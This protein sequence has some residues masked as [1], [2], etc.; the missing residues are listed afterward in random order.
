MST[1]RTDGSRPDQAG[2]VLFGKT[3]R[4]VLGWLYGHADQ[5]FYLREI[6]RQAGSAQGAVQRELEALTRAGLL[7]RTVRG[8]HVYFQAN[9]NSLIYVELQQILLK[10]AGLTD[11]LREAL[12]PLV[13]SIRVAFVFGSAARR[14][15]RA[16]S[17]IDLLVVGDVM[18]SEVAHAVARAQ[19][20]LARD[21]NPSV[22]PP[23]EF[24]AKVRS[25][26]HF[27]GTVL[28]QPKLFVIGGPN[29]LVRLGAKRVA[30]EAHDGPGRDAG[31][32]RRRGKG[33][34]G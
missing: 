10:T 25:G 32:A 17:D 9:V 24:L 18:F 11:V 7:S 22:Y 4:R 16:G 20:R 29:E 14:E 21:V 27:V 28:S 3:R 6:V 12:A 31:L 19:K 5:A 13:E 1:R 33:P 30:D 23:A 26:H 2:I 8:R 15:L 34:G